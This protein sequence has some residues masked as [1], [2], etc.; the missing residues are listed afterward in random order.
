MSA[1]AS[2]PMMLGLMMISTIEL[3]SPTASPATAP[4]V[5]KRRQ[6][7]REHD[8]RQIRA[9]AATAKAR[10]TRNATLTVG[11][12]LIASS[13]RDRADDERGDARHAH[14]F[15]GPPLRAVVDDIRVEIVREA[16]ARADRQA[17]DDRED[18]GEGDRAR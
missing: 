5:L 10:P 7:M 16:G 15:A 6:K 14:F 17:G 4:A 1:L 3:T 2:V 9:D 11:P 12:S 8:H 13:D 18:R